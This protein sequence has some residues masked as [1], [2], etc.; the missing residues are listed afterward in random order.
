MNNLPKVVAQQRRGRASNPRLLDRQVRRP[1][2]KPP[3]HCNAHSVRRESKSYSYIMVC[4]SFSHLSSLPFSVHYASG[5]EGGAGRCSSPARPHRR[6]V[7]GRFPHRAR[8]PGT[9]FP[10]SF[11]TQPSPSTF[12]DN[13]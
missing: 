2:T 13:P 3:S 4:V 10:R 9:L 5:A 8:C 1:T 6:L 11:V 12:P 7:H